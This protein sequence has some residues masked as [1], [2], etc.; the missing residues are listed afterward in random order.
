MTHHDEIMALHD[1]GRDPGAG[2]PEQFRDRSARNVENRCFH[3]HV[4]DTGSAVGLLDHVGV[5]LLAVEAM[6]PFHIILVARKPA[7][8]QPPDNTPFLS[9]GAGWRAAS[10]FVGDRPR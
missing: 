4:F 1:I 2:T 10:A 6:A 8:G 5:P 3:H 9:D 7:P